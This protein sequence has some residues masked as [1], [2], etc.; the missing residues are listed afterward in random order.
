VGRAEAY[1]TMGTPSSTVTTGNERAGSNAEG[2]VDVTGSPLLRTVTETPTDYWNDS[3]SV[4]EL[5]YAISHGATGATTNPTIVGEVLTKELDLWRER[6]GEIVAANPTWTEDEVTWRLIEEMAVRG[7]EL[8]GPVFEREGRR[9]GRLSIQTD[10]KLYR[11]SGRIVEQALHFGTLA[12]NIQV[13][14]AATKAGVEAIEEVTAAGV[15]INATVS[16]TVAQAIAVAEAVE[17]GLAR[18]RSAGADVSLMSP[19]CTMMVGRLED[20]LGVL[21]DREKLAVTPGAIQWGGVACFKRA[22]ALY[23]ERG[24][25]TRML[26][27]A[28]RHHRHWSE[29]IGGDIV[30][31]IPHRWQVLINGS[32]IEVRPRIDDPVPD[33]ALAELLR[34]FPDFG[35]AYE[36]EGLRPA[37][38]DRFGPTVRTLRQFIASYEELAARIRDFMLPNPD[39]A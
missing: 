23:R 13:K 2:G 6:I 34:L 28:Y 21:A 5:E 10:P 25:T 22:Y 36:P 32:D 38:F 37:D 35:R 1:A 12:P 4:A 8:L 39:Q 14:V 30:L 11:D 17:R 18:R 19:V 9:K 26:A 33:A 31:T 7:T 20:W 15:N 29:L 16:F 27:A 3:C 24:Y